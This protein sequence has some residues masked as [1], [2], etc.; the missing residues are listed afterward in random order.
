MN[1]INDLLELM[2]ALRDPQSGCPWDIRQ[3]SVSIAPYTLVET[4]EL[5]DAIERND[6]ENL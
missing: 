6:M 4:H 2:R 5:L 1:S 3:T